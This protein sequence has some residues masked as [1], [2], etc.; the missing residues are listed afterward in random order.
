[1]PKHD[2]QAILFDLDGTLVDSVYQHVHAWHGALMQHGFKVPHYRIHRGI[3]LPSNRLLR[4]LLGAAPEAESALI[5]AHDRIFLSLAGT[6]GPTPGAL[7]LLADLDA[8]G[9][10]YLAV[11]SAS[12]TTQKVLFD[13]LG[14]SMSIAPSSGS[15]PEPNPMLA[16][17]K[18]LA[19]DPQHLTMIGDAV[20]D[21]ESAHRSGMHF[22]GLR[23]GGTSDE[24]LRQAGA[25]W[26]E[27]GP[28]DL[29]GRL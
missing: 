19:R 10:S 29:V 17:A 5:E 13:G 24:L 9:V 16:A 7:E 12:A 26:V 25:L 27:D 11:T 23:C 3:G 28:R 20:W 2:D 21:A 22:V 6:L 14:R 1:M 15:K 8:R 4:W 18:A